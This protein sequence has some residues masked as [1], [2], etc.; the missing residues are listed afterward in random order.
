[1]GKKAVRGKPRKSRATAESGEGVPR[2]AAEADDEEDFEAVAAGIAERL[3]FDLPAEAF[4]GLAPHALTE[5]GELLQA[6]G[7]FRAKVSGL[8]D[9]ACH[10]LRRKLEALIGGCGA[11]DGASQESPASYV[12]MKVQVLLSYLI[13]LSYYLVLKTSGVPVKEH[14]V[15]PRLLWLRTLL[16]KLKPVDQRLQ[17]Q[18]KRLLE[19]TDARKA[20][21]MNEANGRGTVDLDARALKPGQLTTTVE[22]DDEADAEEDEEQEEAADKEGDTHL[23]AYRPPRI[24]QV[25]YTGDHVSMQERAEK[26][27]ERKKARLERSEFMRTLREEFTD[28]PKEIAG[29]LRS[30]R[31]DKAAR[32]MRERQEYEEETMQRQRLTKAESRKQRQTLRQS[33]ATSGGAVSLYDVAADFNDIARS[34]ESGEGKGKGKKRGGGGVLQEYHSAKARVHSM[35][36]SLASAAEG[37]KGGGREQLKRA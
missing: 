27:L 19:W 34:L 6:L 28:A 16:E 7:Q 21:L 36:S 1:M 12:E 14:P 37:S 10:A 4:G 9:G 23:G 5:R 24:S 2:E 31:A 11:D 33:R 30:D 32:L 35:R 3:R 25:E 18:M 26:D 15:V 29:E 13:A 22:D 20:E 17:F 8:R